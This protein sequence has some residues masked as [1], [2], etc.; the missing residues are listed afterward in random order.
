MTNFLEL[1][2]H[3]VVIVVF[4][5]YLFYLFY[6]FPDLAMLVLVAHHR[7]HLRLLGLKNL[8]DKAETHWALF[9]LG[10][11]AA[12]FVG[13]CGSAGRTHHEGL[14]GAFG[15]SEGLPFLLRALVYERLKV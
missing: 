3:F 7:L 14:H 5:A 11:A 2:R 9:L 12:L 4:V 13:S 8:L 6:F 10:Y 1:M 15:G